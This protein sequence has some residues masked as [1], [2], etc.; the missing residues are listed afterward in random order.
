[1]YVK[2]CVLRTD[3]NMVLKILT[4]VSDIFTSRESVGAKGLF[5]SFSGIISLSK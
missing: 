2:V 1:M 5:V 4:G 3:S